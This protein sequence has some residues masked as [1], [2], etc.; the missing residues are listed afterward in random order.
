MNKTPTKA[1]NLIS[2]IVENAQQFGTTAPEHATST[3]EVSEFRAELADLTTLVKQT[4]FAK[5]QESQKH[6]AEV[7]YAGNQQGGWTYNYNR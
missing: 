7:N 3:Q 2:T 4:S 5:A 6:A 1:R